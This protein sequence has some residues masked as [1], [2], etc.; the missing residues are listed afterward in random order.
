MILST[1]TNCDIGIQLQHGS[2]DVGC[3]GHVVTHSSLMEYDYTQIKM[4]LFNLLLTLTAVI[5]C[6]LPTMLLYVVQDFLWGRVGAINF[7][8]F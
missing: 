8:N 5:T 4:M 6:Y 3:Q 2:S 1:D 7:L